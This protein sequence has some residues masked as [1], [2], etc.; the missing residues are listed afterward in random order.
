MVFNDAKIKA[1]ET[2]ADMFNV[3]TENEKDGNTI[4]IND[5]F[6]CRTNK[7]IVDVDCKQLFV[8]RYIDG[9][10]ITTGTIAI[11]DIKSMYYID[12]TYNIVS[13]DSIEF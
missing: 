8:E 6:H 10:I 3:E 9:G 13:L 4:T 1:V 5:V 12:D 7:I 11:E 2:L